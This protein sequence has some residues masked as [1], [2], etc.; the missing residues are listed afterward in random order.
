MVA[1]SILHPV[2]TINLRMKVQITER[3]E[4]NGIIRST[5]TVIRNEGLKA[6]WSGWSTTM[7]ASPLIASI[8]FSTYESLK[9]FALPRVS[10]SK[11]SVV[12]FLSGAC[13]EL[14]ISSISVPVEV[15]KSRLQLGRN[16]YLAS[17]GAVTRTQN[18]SGP[19]NAIKTILRTEGIRGFY[20]G[21][22][23]CLSVDTTFSA[24]SF[25][26]YET[27]KRTYRDY[28]HK[29][30]RRDREFTTAETLVM[31]SLAGG[32]SAW[33]TNPLDVMTIRI[34]T[35]G[36]SGRYTGLRH[37]F[38]KTIGEEGV[39]ALWKGATCRMMTIMPQVGI[40]FGV[41]E[42]IKRWLFNGELEEFDLE[43][44]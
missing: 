20:T 24:F 2:D 38:A 16:P 25:L 9:A 3:P 29:R 5:L 34:M 40:T 6:C 19:F 13:S 31:G 33:I 17:G 44:L 21:Y 18:Y 14:V 28:I 36:T 7:M 23:A 26:T 4:Y 1:D 22:T 15:V 27:L 41:Y 11:S 42:T 39:T 43:D 32:C 30:E 8:Y 37:F 35:A 12:F 10:E